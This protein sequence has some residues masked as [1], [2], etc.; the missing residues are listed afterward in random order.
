MDFYPG[1]IF[2][3]TRRS[4]SE[5]GLP[6]S[7]PPGPL[8]GEKQSTVFSLAVISRQSSVI[9]LRRPGHLLVT[10]SLSKGVLSSH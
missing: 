4:F 1:P 2:F 5:G 10:L 6:P 8:K 9:S 3:I 7:P